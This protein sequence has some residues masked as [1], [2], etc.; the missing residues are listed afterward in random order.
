MVMFAELKDAEIH[1]YG[2]AVDFNAIARAIHKGRHGASALFPF[3]DP[4]SKFTTLITRCSG[5]LGSIQTVGQEIQILYSEPIKN[6]FYSYF[7]MPA[8]TQAGSIF[9]VRVSQQ[10]HPPV[11]SENSLSLVIHVVARAA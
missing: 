1:I 9:L 7:S 6:R 5:Q 10:E 2:S 11:L 8:E 4:S 3:S